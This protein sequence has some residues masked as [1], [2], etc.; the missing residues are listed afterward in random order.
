M[1]LSMRIAGTVLWTGYTVVLAR[2]LSPQDFA[3]ALYVMNFSFLGVLVVTIGRDV[4]LLKFGSRSW[5]IGN[6]VAI[7]RIH[8]RTRLVLVCSSAVLVVALLLAWAV[9][10]DTPVTQD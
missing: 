1:I 7:R 9:G 5:A 3:T 10:L 6:R 2:S 8:V 4:A